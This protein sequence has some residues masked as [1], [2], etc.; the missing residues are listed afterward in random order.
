MFA[1]C[2]VTLLFIYRSLV[3][4][5]HSRPIYRNWFRA[6][7]QFARI[8]PCR[9]FSQDSTCLVDVHNDELDGFEDTHNFACACIAYC[10]PSGVFNAILNDSVLNMRYSGLSDLGGRLQQSQTA[11]L[12]N[13]QHFP[14]V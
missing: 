6:E 13:S 7:L 11:L 14:M 2:G 5:N 8:W 9:D 1:K 12:L 10:A 3:C 4:T